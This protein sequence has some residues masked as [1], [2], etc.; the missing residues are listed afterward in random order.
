[1]NKREED[2]YTP[3]HIFWRNRIEGQ[4]RHAINEHPEWFNLPNELS[5]KKCVNG[6]AK[7]VI[8]EIIAATRRGDDTGIGGTP[9]ANSGLRECAMSSADPNEAS[10]STTASLIKIGNGRQGE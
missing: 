9:P 3:A 6:I 7:R 8:G 1:M 10:G 5:Y 2:K 4:I